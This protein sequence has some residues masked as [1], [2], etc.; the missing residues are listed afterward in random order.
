MKEMDPVGGGGGTCQW[1]PPGSANAYG[2]QF[3]C[4]RIHFHRKAPTLEVHT[5]LMGARPLWEMLDPPLQLDINTIIPSMPNFIVM[6]AISRVSKWLDLFWM[7]LCGHRCWYL[8]FL[9]GHLLFKLSIH[10][11]QPFGSFVLYEIQKLAETNTS[12]ERNCCNYFC[13][14]Q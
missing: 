5:P 3:F 7:Y 13:V 9:C 8:R 14:I 11:Y 1:H 12:I 2:T 6:A 4:F 10:C